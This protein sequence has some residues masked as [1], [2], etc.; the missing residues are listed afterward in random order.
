[1]VQGPRQRHHRHPDHRRLDARPT[2][3]P[4]CAAPAS[5]ASPRCRSGQAGGN[6]SAENG[7]SSLAIPKAEQEQGAGLRVHGVRERRRGRSD[8]HRRRRLPGHHRADSAR[9]RSSNKEFRVLRRPE[10]Q[11]DLRRVRRERRQAA[12]RTCRSRSTPTASSTTPSARRTSPARRSPTA[13]RPGRTASVKYGTEQGFTVKIVQ[14]R[15]R[16][17]HGPPRVTPHHCPSPRPRKEIHHDPRLT[18]PRW[19]RWRRNGTR[20]ARL[21]RRLQPRA[22]AAGGV[23]G[24][25]AAHARGR[26]QHRVAGDLLLGPYPAGRGHLGLRLARRGHGPAARQRHRRR[27]GH[28]DRI[29]ATVAGHR[30]PGDPAGDR[31]GETVW[32]GGRQHWRPTSPVFRGT[33]CGWSARWRSATRTTRRSRPGTSPTSSAATTSTTTPTTPPA[34]FRGWLQAR[35]STLDALNARLGHRVLVAALQRLG[36]D[37]AAAAGRHPPEPHPAAGLQALLL[38]RAAGLPARRTRHPQRASPPTS[39]SPPTSW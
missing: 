2:S 8:P 23:G 18:V 27:P 24:G 11:R 1:M 12:G 32:P 10:G 7:G 37:P 20:A 25:R 33:R 6:A 34:A 3:T 39:P 31:N 21:R 35:Y 26:R 14:Y 16:P 22:V 15:A 4:A 17:R 28:R 19:L 13:S 9:R 29:A 38:G 30:A 36:P 5:G